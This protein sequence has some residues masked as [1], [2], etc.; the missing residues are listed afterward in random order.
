MLDCK[1][2]YEIYF[3]V[4]LMQVTLAFNVA[5]L[6]LDRFRYSQ[7]ILDL[8]DKT[9][10]E[11]RRFPIDLQFAIDTY[12]KERENFLE[13]GIKTKVYLKYFGPFKLFSLNNDNNNSLDIYTITG[14]IIILTMLL[15]FSCVYQ[16]YDNV[17]LFWFS[18]AVSI[19]GIV[20]PLVFIR[21]GNNILVEKNKIID[22]E[23]KHL[24]IKQYGNVISEMKVKTRSIRNKMEKSR[25][26][27][28]K[29]PTKTSGA[30]D[31]GEKIPSV[32]KKQ[33]KGKAKKG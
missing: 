30:F 12:S 15:V 22:I 18:W 25:I 26:I 6:A 14:S 7:R 32:L 33:K 9:I 13:E 27:D 5:Y 20:L 23:L 19:A 10:D 4:P 16:K 8:Y 31:G 11:I 17:N 24:R 2:S 21:C 3:L 28:K 29:S 1:V